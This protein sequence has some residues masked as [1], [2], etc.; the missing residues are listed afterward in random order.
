MY[1]RIVILCAAPQASAALIHSPINT[2]HAC[3]YVRIGI[4]CAA[5][6]ASAALIHSPINTVHACIYVRI[7]ILCAAPQASAAL[8][9][10]PINMCVRH[11][12]P[13][14]LSFIHSFPHKYVI[15]VCG[16]AGQCRSHS[17]PHKYMCAAPQASAALFHS[18]RYCACMCV[19]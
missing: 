10:S 17:F 7:G 4:L 19:L 6:Q 11:R 5:P 13:V 8:I 9:H 2:V 3:M 18:P 1:V 12:R 16:T 14:P 15:H